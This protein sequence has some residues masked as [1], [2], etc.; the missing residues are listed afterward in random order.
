MR[1]VAHGIDLIHCERIARIW[2]DHGERFLRRVYTGRE[3]AYCL[4]CKDPVIRLSGRFAAKEAVMKMLGTGWRG[5]IEWT[6]IETLPDPLGKPLVTLRGKTAE[7]ATTLG[8]HQILISISH[9]GD[10]ALASA[11]GV[12]PQAGSLCHK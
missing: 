1:I 8:I 5:G 10:Y 9:S 3:R 6:D 11:I 12:G 7:M 2:K 4:D